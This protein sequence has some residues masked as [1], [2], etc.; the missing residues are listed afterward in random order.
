LLPGELEL[1]PRLE[2]HGGAAAKQR[3]RRPPRVLA[4]HR[5]AML[6]GEHLEDPQNAP[7]AEVG[8]RH[9]RRLEDPR[10]LALGTAATRRP[11]LARLDEWH[12]Q[13]I[14][15]ANRLEV[16]G[17]GRRHAAASLGL[18]CF[19]RGPEVGCRLGDACCASYRRPRGLKTPKR[20][21]CRR[22]IRSRR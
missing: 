14:A 3:D 17:L 7:L 10:L 11:W 2:R 8:H 18:G 15:P 13:I 16:A 21:P 20:Q 4:L 1:P 19:A 12:E 22:A 5:P 9:T 6:G